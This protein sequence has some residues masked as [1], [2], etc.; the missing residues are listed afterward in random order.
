MERRIP[1]RKATLTLLVMLALAA[2]AAAQ[3]KVSST[4]QCGKPDKDYKLDVGDRPGHAFEIAQ[5]KCVYTKG[6]VEGIQI[7]E[8][9][10]TGYSENSGDAAR[11]QYASQ[12]SMA[13]G[14][15]INAHGDFTQAWKGGVVQTEEGRWN[16]TGGTGKFKGVKGKGTYKIKFAADGTSAAEFEGEYTLPAAK[17]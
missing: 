15:K 17:K 8:E 13:N 10:Y 3:N 6:E 4:I 5:G 11:G 7:K 9:M 14:D 12:I 16:Y 1:M 2:S